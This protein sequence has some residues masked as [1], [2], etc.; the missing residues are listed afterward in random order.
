MKKAAGIVFRS[1]ILLLLG[2]AI[3][4]LI[5]D[6]FEGRNINFSVAKR[7]KVSKVLDLVSNNYV[8]SVNMD[9]IEGSTVNGLLQN[10]DPHS[11]YLPAQPG[12]KHQ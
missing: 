11:L 9:S 6:N 3:G 4:L 2:I 8:D 1:V 5:S 7:D 10:L 12:R